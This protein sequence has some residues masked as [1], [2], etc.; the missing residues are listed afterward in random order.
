MKCQSTIRILF[1]VSLT[2][3]LAASTAIAQHRVIT[4]GKG[5]LAI[6]DAEGQIEWEMKWGGIHDIQVLESGNILTRK[7][8][9]QV[10]EIDPKTKQVVWSYNS[11]TENGNEGKKVEVHAFQALETGIVMIAESGPARIIEVN[12]DGKLLKKIKLKRYKNLAR[13]SWTL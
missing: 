4:Q 8:P 12:R 1:F 2:I 6:V 11:A 7:G 10:V 5:K 3:S 9:S 13:A